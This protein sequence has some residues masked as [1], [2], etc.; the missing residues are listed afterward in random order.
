M[1][2]LL[3]Y[4][5][6]SAS[7]SVCKPSDLRRTTSGVVTGTPNEVN[8]CSRMK[9][10][11]IEICL[12]RYRMADAYSSGRLAL[13]GALFSFSGDRTTFPLNVEK[14]ESMP[15]YLNGWSEA[16]TLEIAPRISMNTRYASRISRR[17]PNIKC[18]DFPFSPNPTP[19]RL[20]LLDNSSRYYLQRVSHP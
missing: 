19:L 12:T 20:Q 5:G 8:L 13:A 9:I 11:D 7:S 17:S 14:V 4:S 15:R 6:P 1:P 18:I 16:Y 3:R 10:Q 2:S